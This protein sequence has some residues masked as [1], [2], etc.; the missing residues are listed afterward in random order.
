MFDGGHRVSQPSAVILRKRRQHRGDL[1]LRAQIQLR[2]SLAALGGEAEAKLSAVGCE[3][4]AR[5]QATLF[6]TLHD[7][8]EIAGIE[9]DL[10]ADFLGRKRVAMRSGER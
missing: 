2:E 7:A 3:R 4:F 8:A 1:V 5:D 9:P 6:K 10:A